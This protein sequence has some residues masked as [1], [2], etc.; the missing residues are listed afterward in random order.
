MK[1]FVFA[2]LAYQFT[3]NDLARFPSMPG[4]RLIE[5]RLKGPR[6]SALE[7][8]WGFRNIDPGWLICSYVD[9][10]H[11]PLEVTFRR[12]FGQY[13]LREIED[14]AIKVF[15]HR[16]DSAGE[17]GS[18]VSFFRDHASDHPSCGHL[19]STLSRKLSPS[20]LIITDGSNTSNFLAKFHRRRREVSSA[21][22]YEEMRRK[23]Y[24][25]GPLSL[26]CVGYAS[27]CYGPTLIWATKRASESKYG[28]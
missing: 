10:Q 19:L 5:E 21:E 1:R 7:R 27:S 18:N 16:G 4:Y 13:A 6:E 11:M 23:V 2:D 25:L 22:A 9:E 17:G 26:S 14:G 20:T 24:R 15:V 28:S 8:P 3:D 12:G